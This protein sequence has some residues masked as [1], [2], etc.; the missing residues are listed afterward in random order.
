MCWESAEKK[1]FVY[2]LAVKP[3][4]QTQ[5]RLPHFDLTQNWSNYR[6]VISNTATLMVPTS[7]SGAVWGSVSCPETLGHADQGNWTCNLPKRLFL[8]LSHSTVVEPVK[9][10]SSCFHPAVLRALTDVHVCQNIRKTFKFTA[11]EF[12]TI[13]QKFTVPE[14]V[15]WKQLTTCCLNTLSNKMLNDSSVASML[16]PQSDMT[17]MN[18]RYCD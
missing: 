13:D 3:A 10:C 17:H 9:V 12:L 16:L 11:D 15:W 4:A 6:S 14:V 7:T 5:Q 8:L 1:H 18:R 2:L